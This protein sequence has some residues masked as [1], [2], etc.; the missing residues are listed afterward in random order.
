MY[1][2][3]REGKACISY[4]LR[5]MDRKQ[6]KTEMKRAWERCFMTQRQ[7]KPTNDGDANPTTQAKPKPDKGGKLP[8]PHCLLTSLLLAGQRPAGHPHR[9]R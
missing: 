6:G 3:E 4:G 5:N 9:C 1:T 8:C 7:R 2:T